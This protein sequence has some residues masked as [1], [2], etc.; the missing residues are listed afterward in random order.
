MT[1]PAEEGIEKAS[2]RKI[3]R[4]SPLQS[5]INES[6]GWN[7]F[8][9]TIEVGA[10]GFVAHSTHRFL[11]K[12]GMHNRLVSKICKSIS[13]VATKCSYE[14]YL[15]HS[16]RF[17]KY[18]RDLLLLDSLCP[19]AMQMASIPTVHKFR[20]RSMD[21]GSNSGL[22]HLSMSPKTAVC[23]PHTYNVIPNAIPRYHKLS[24][25]SVKLPCSK[26]EIREP[27]LLATQPSL[28]YSFVSVTQLPCPVM[29]ATN[30][31]S[32]VTSKQPTVESKRR[33]STRLQK[34]FHLPSPGNVQKRFCTDKKSILIFRK[35]V[36]HQKYLECGTCALR[37]SHRIL[38]LKPPDIPDTNSVDACYFDHAK[39]RNSDDR[40]F[41]V[42]NLYRLNIDDPVASNDFDSPCFHAFQKFGQGD[43]V[44]LLLNLLPGKLAD[45]NKLGH[46]VAIGL[47]HSTDNQNGFLVICDSLAQHEKLPIPS[48]ALTIA[49]HMSLQ[50]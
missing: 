8:V 47:M 11:R 13:L 36:P 31:T 4:Y 29:N 5:S 20:P 18:R 33:K 10:R 6:T 49:K 9:M 37:N 32:M 41:I 25:L 30:P 38:G 44:A 2:K 3:T 12:L 19:K 16:S 21:E 23:V 24:V 15:A 50:L 45:R 7:C 42:G 14:I 34:P 48:W 43:D 46:W 40:I 1:C 22:K 26:P 28:P 35:P 39:L 17:W 27:K